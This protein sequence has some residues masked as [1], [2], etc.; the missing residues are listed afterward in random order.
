MKTITKLKL[1]GLALFMTALMIVKF[2]I[3]NVYGYFKFNITLEI[4]YYPIIAIMSSIG[5][6]LISSRDKVKV[7]REKQDAMS[8]NFL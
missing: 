8:N 4:I 7:D 6:Y 5:A 3:S 2:I 1:L